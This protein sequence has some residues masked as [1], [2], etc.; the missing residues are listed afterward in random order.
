M[1]DFYTQYM[2]QVYGKDKAVNVPLGCARVCTCVCV[3]LISFSSGFMFF[4]CPPRLCPPHCA[5][6]GEASE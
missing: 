1:F 5:D 4:A 3:G 6:F 2:R